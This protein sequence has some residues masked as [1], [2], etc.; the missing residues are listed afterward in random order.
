MASP[1]LSGG[2]FLS[3][4]SAIPSVDLQV[5][6]GGAQR[7]MRRED[8]NGAP[9]GRRQAPHLGNHRKPVDS[10]QRQVADEEDRR[11]A[12]LKDPGRSDAVTDE[13]GLDRVAF[14]RLTVDRRLL[15]VEFGDKHV[16]GHVYRFL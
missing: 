1:I 12:R 9:I 8:E 6:G 5:Q 3:P 14:D 2:W 7:G 10:R 4:T 15:A 16:L 11:A 13:H